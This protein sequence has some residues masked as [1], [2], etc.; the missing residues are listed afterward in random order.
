MLD[1]LTAEHPGRKG[2]RR[3]YRA[4]R[5]RRQVPRGEERQKVQTNQVGAAPP[6]KSGQRLPHP[7]PGTSQGVNAQRQSPCNGF[8]RKQGCVVLPSLS[9]TSPVHQPPPPH[10][11]ADLPCSASSHTAWPHRRTQ[12]WPQPPC[13]RDVSPAHLPPCQLQGVTVA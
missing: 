4:E 11:P 7:S 10:R 9:P 2:G 6:S 1:S 5:G 8:I 13:P 3:K 12:T